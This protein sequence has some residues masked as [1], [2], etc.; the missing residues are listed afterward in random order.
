MNTPRKKGVGGGLPLNSP[1]FPNICPNTPKNLKKNE[2]NAFF[3]N[4]IIV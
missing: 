2:R 1:E 3:I 4:K